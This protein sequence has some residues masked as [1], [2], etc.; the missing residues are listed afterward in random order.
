M[1]QYLPELVLGHTLLTVIIATLIIATL[2]LSRLLAAG[3]PALRL[4]SLRGTVLVPWIK[5][6][7][8][9]F[10]IA[11]IAYIAGYLSTMSR[12]TAV[13][14][15]LPAVLTLIGGLNIYVFGTDIKY[16]VLISYCVCVF[17]LMLFYGSQYGGYLREASR[18]YRLL[19]LTRQEL[20]IKT[21]RR[22]LGLPE[23]FP[24]WLVSSEPK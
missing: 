8:F 11:L 15:V 12:T 1:E 14:T 9:T 21:V 10:P 16:R 24:P 2:G 13:G 6:V 4:L 7:A 20:Q 19:Q 23:D 22:N 18:D 5:F 17:A 3:A